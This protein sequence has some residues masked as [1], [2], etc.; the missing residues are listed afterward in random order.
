MIRKGDIPG[1][2][3]SNCNMLKWILI[4]TKIP[5]EPLINLELLK[6]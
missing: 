1:E 2:D 6:E 5:I 3:G 4:L